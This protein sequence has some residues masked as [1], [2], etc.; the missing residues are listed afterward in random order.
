[1]GADDRC[2]LPR[3]VPLN[4]GVSVW[5]RSAS[6]WLPPV[7]HCFLVDYFCHRFLRWTE[8]CPAMLRFSKIRLLNEA[9]AGLWL[10]VELGVSTDE[11]E[12]GPL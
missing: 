3:I 10:H 12:E 1:M 4:L 7:D 8:T 9:I 5:R 2:S 11:A 6:S